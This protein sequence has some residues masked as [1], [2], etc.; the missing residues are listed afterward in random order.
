MATG[1]THPTSSSGV[2]SGETQTLMLLCLIAS[3]VI[4]CGVCIYV[5]CDLQ[6]ASL[7]TS[8]EIDSDDD[9]LDESDDF[10]RQFRAQ[11]FA[12]MQQGQAQGQEP[13]VA[14]VEEHTT[15]VPLPRY[16]E[17]VDVDKDFHVSEPLFWADGS[18]APGAT[19]KEELFLHHLA[20]TD[21]RVTTVVHAY[22]SNIKVKE[23]HVM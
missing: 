9:L 10:M 19:S 23:W 14:A 4:E 21:P 18:S 1:H 12:E 2:A 11:R 13:H 16:G 3:F 22:E 6:A 8:Q 5:W 7:P 15:A 20:N 17:V